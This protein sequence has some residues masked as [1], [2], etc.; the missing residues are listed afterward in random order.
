MPASVLGDVVGFR[1][2][3][4]GGPKDIL[5]LLEVRKKIQAGSDSAL[6]QAFEMLENRESEP[7]TYIKGQI[8]RMYEQICRTAA[9]NQ[10]ASES[11]QRAVDLYREAGQSHRAAYLEMLCHAQKCSW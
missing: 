2:A 3:L 1:R 5:Y 11:K 9:Q 4:S 6:N 10:L 8:A 7:S